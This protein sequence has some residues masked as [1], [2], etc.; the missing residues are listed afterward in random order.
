MA[1]VIGTDPSGPRKMYVSLTLSLA[2]T[3][4]HNPIVCEVFV[5][6][7]MINVSFLVVFLLLPYYSI[8]L[9]NKVLN[10]KRTNTVVVW[11]MLQV[12]QREIRWGRGGRFRIGV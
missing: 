6:D 11:V 5:C 8:V 9:V 7:G 10:V 4:T 3:Y 2:S 1:F 12:D